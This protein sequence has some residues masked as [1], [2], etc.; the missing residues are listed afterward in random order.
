[1]IDFNQKSISL[2][3]GCTEQHERMKAKG[4][5]DSDVSE[6]KKMGIDSV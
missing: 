2:S 1:M 5:Y 6:T 4:F 3:K